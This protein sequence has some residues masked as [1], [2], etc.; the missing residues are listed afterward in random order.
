MPDNARHEFDVR[1]IDFHLRRE[2]ISY[3]EYEKH[4][5]ELEDVADNCVETSTRFSNAYEQRHVNGSKND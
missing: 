5:N 1:V 3:E 2:S 4:L